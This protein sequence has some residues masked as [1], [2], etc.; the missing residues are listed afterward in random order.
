MEIMMTP[1]IDVVFLLLI[2][3]LT[4]SSFEILEQ[5]LP[6]GISDKGIVAA[7]NT[8]NIPPPEVFTDLNDCIVKIVAKPGEN[9]T[10]TY[11]FNGASIATPQAI[12]QRLRAII[13][14]RADIPIIVDPDDSVP[15]ALAVEIYDQARAA[16]GLQVFFAAR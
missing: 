8:E 13:A 9:K 3:F 15:I 7:G 10:Y 6:S 11:E 2:F 4:T 14:V 16:G 12:A 5:L 1:M